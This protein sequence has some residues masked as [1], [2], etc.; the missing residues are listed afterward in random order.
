MISTVRAGTRPACYVACTVCQAYGLQPEWTDEPVWTGRLS[1][2]R[3]TSWGWS[4]T[5]DLP[6]AL[7]ELR[8]GLS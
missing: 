3:A 7:A 6:T 5:V 1:P 8:D 2:T 4:P